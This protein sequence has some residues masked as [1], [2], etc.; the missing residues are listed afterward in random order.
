MITRLY[1]SNYRS[2]GEGLDL[3]LG[4]LTVLVGPNGSGKSNIIDVFQFLHDCVE[5]SPGEAI[6]TRQG[7]RSLTRWSGGKPHKIDI[8]AEIHPFRNDDETCG[9]WGF[10]I[11]AGAEDEFVVEREYAY[12]RGLCNYFRGDAGPKASLDDFLR[13][14]DGTDLPEATFTVLNDQLHAFFRTSKGW[15]F[16]LSHS[17][18]T[19]PYLHTGP[20]DLYFPFADY[21]SGVGSLKQLPGRIAIYSLFPN[22][23]RA[24]Q[25][26]E[27]RQTD[28]IIG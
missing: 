16:P 6:A 5:A 26:P 12:S 1:A 18:H 21:V 9:F 22:T 24:A 10:T 2:I 27:P 7:F 28:E 3:R 25:N 11:S 14:A 23:L 19:N 15:S 8:A 17:I 4:P 13:S 20:M